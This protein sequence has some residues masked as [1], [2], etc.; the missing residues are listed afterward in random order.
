MN[1][2]L[3]VIPARMKSTRFPGKPLAVAGGKSLL[4]HTYNRAFETNYN[5]V[6][7][8]SADDSELIEHCLK[9]NMTYVTT[10]ESCWC[11]TV[12]VWHVAKKFPDKKVVVN[13]Q[14][15]EPEVEPKDVLQLIDCAKIMNRGAVTMY[16]PL[17]FV[18]R[19]D[20]NMVKVS[21]DGK[22]SF[23]CHWFSRTYMPGSYLH[24][25]VYAFPKS[26]LTACAVT[27]RSRLSELEDL[28]QLS[29]MELPG[30]TI[31]GIPIK[32]RNNTAFIGGINT[33]QDMREFEW[34]LQHRS[35][36]QTG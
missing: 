36:C 32:G 21:V 9:H 26:V 24:V 13:W 14:V 19:E 1:D 28:E 30:F 20:S 12:R 17:L 22:V 18:D 35:R 2:A 6:V 10:P 34:R 29:W 8:V 27:K 11:G 25:G 31:Q 5:T 23:V 16:S 4:Q 33:P 15:D 3:I 7:A